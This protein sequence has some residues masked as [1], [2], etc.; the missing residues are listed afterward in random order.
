MPDEDV[1]LKL[2]DVAQVLFEQ[3]SDQKEINQL[4]LARWMAHDSSGKSLKGCEG[5]LDMSNC[6]TMSSST[7][8]NAIRLTSTYSMHTLKNADSYMLQMY[9]V[10]K[11]TVKSYCKITRAFI[12]SS[13]E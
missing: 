7:S 9:R 4:S 13:G 6:L 1:L 12:D 2:D 3:F 5:S 8:L 11:K 10:M